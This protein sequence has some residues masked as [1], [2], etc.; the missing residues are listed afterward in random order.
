MKLDAQM[1]RTADAE[2]ALKKVETDKKWLNRK[3]KTT[4]ERAENVEKVKRE[5]DREFLRNL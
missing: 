2:V 5:A 4:M 3:L 1:Q